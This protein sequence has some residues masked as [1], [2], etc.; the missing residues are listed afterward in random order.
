VGAFTIPRMSGWV[1]TRGVGVL[2]LYVPMAME[3]DDW[4]PLLDAVQAAFTVVADP[5]IETVVIHRFDPRPA[6]DLMDATLESLEAIL[7]A[8]HVAVRYED[9]RPE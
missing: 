6:S 7:A 1:L 5:P 3:P 8:R 4:P 9:I 2:H